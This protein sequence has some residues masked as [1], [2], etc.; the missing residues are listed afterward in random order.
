VEKTSRLGC[1]FAVTL[2]LAGCASS[3]QPPLSSAPIG[4]GQPFASQQSAQR[5]STSWMTRSDRAS[6]LVY[7]SDYQNNDVVVFNKKGAVQGQIGGFN[8]PVGLFVDRKHNVW[9]ANARDHDVL[10]YA[11]GSTTP[12]LTLNDGTSFPVDVAI[13]PNRRVYVVNQVV[14]FSSPGNIAVYGPGKLN[15][16][17]FLSWPG[18]FVLGYAA[19][20][21]ANNLFVT[22]SNGG[23]DARVIEF[24]NAEQYGAHDLG[25]TLSYAGGIKIDTA[26][27]LLVVDPINFKINEYT[28]TGKLTGISISTGTGQISQIA[29]AKNGDLVGGADGT[30]Y[31]R[32]GVSWSY[33]DGTQ[34]QTYVLPGQDIEPYGF[35]FD[36]S[37]R[38]H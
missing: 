37:Y 26:G 30:L 5:V 15:P 19:C 6:Q 9:V 21:A 17:G 1:V 8:F 13:C 2:A 31:Q 14:S 36:P 20:D 11:R 22:A 3:A 12:F 29:L 34:R 27:N 32:W 4:R 33:P 16:G 18:E 28:E 38:D 35:A 24:P 23:S 25:I 10:V 7:V